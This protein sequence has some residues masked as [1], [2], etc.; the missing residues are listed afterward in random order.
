MNLD[1]HGEVVYECS[2]THNEATLALK[3]NTHVEAVYER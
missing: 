1:V 3:L 2:T